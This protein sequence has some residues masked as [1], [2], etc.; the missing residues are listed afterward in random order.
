M[1]DLPVGGRP[2]RL[3][4]RKRLWRCLEPACP[5]R[6]WSEESALIGPRAVLTE[7][8]RVWAMLRV[9]REGETVAAVARQLRVGWHTVMRAVREYGR[10]LVEDPDRL[11][12]VVGLGV[13]EH[14]WQH[15]G[16]ARRTGY[17]T[18]IVELSPGRPPRLLDVV[19]G[20][21]GKVYADWI[22]GHE[23]AWRDRIRLAA[24]DPFRGY[25][26]ALAGALPDAV[27]VL[28]AFH[29]VK[30]ANDAVDDVRRRVQQDTLGHRGRK[31]DPLYEARRLL[32]RGAEN[33]TPR[34]RERLDAAL[35]AG[36]PDWEVTV[37]WSCAQQVRAVYHAPPPT[38]AGG[39]RCGYSTPCPPAHLPAARDRPARPHPA[40]LAR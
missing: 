27:R 7:R 38:P 34:A 37:A 19:P 21:T 1:R 29:V 3:T 23:Q 17:A 4:W 22:A 15:A 20:R 36:D 31:G 25:A 40:V 2:V 12:G 8:A 10:P 11:A 33:L 35:Q 6:T 9:G 24:L 14:V 26:T 28:D 16:P 39:R 5:T 18:G 32:R 30:L 13:D